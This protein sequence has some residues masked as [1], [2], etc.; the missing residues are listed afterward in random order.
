LPYICQETEVGPVY[1]FGS[2]PFTTP[3]RELAVAHFS[4]FFSG[5]NN[6]INGCTMVLVDD[7]IMPQGGCIGQRASGEH[8]IGRN[9][10]ETQK[11]Q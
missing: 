5:L 10:A 9:Q 4:T 1:D 3:F 6:R 7:E 2:P 11:V 8:E